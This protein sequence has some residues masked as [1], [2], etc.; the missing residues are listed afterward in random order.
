MCVDYG[1][2]D[3]ARWLLDRR[4]DVDSRAVV[5]RDGFGGHTA[6]FNAVVSYY[7]YVKSKYAKPKPDRDPFAQLL[8]DR[9]ANP[10]VRASLRTRV[11]DETMHEYRNVTPL[12]WGEQFHAKEL[13]SIPAL[14]LIAER[15]GRA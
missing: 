2:L 12:E 3:I 8:L 6:L 10:N 7:Y 11:H 5:D 13:V 1:E 15:V 9:G 4:T 14:R